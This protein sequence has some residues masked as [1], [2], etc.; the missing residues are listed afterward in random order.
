MAEGVPAKSFLNSQFLSG[1][2]Q[3]LL[4]DCLPPIRLLSMAMAAGKDPVFRLAILRSFPPLEECFGDKGNKPARIA[5]GSAAKAVPAMPFVPGH[6]EVVT[7]RCCLLIRFTQTL[8]EGFAVWV[9]EFLVALLPCRFQFGDGDV[10]VGSAFL[11]HCSQV[12]A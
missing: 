3:I 8:N 4:Q 9:E 10:P 6:P 12:L 11:E 2:S 7:K 1:W 5:P